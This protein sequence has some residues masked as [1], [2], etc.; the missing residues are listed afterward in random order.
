MSVTAMSRRLAVQSLES[1]RDL[2]LDPTVIHRPA[3]DTREPHAAEAPA[4]TM[5]NNQVVV[6]DIPAQ[7]PDLQPRP[8]LLA[9]LNRASQGQPAVVLTGTWG[10]GKTQL[11]AAYARARLAGGCG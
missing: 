11:A 7:R 9:Q 5:V 2:T 1:R 6:G 4:R 10:V 8:S 3:A